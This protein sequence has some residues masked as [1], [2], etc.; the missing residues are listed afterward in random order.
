MSNLTLHSDILRIVC[1]SII[2]DAI[3]KYLTQTQQT[4]FTHISLTSEAKKRD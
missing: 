1:S 3:P 2:L 4:Y